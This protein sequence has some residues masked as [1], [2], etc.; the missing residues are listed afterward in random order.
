M[1]SM[2]LMGV[3]AATA[4]LSAPTKAQDAQ[5]IAGAWTYRSFHND[6]APVG[7]DPQAA[8][9]L[10]FAEATFTFSIVADNRLE[11]TIDWGSGG[12]DLTGT[13]AP[14]AGDESVDVEIIGMGRPGTQTDGWRYDYSGTLAHTWSN[15]VDQRP[16]IVGS[17][18]RTLP[19]GNAPAG[20]VASFV[21]VKRD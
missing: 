6:P 8:L 11:G 19:H 18:I 17:V 7:G 21:A 12:L 15:G 13:I 5:T 16:A 1:R 14:V 4:A 2:I 3:L 9:G 10:F 20:Y